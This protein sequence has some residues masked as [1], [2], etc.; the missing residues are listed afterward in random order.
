MWFKYFSKANWDMRLWRYYN[1]KYDANEF[2]FT[3]NMYFAYLHSL[4]L[5]IARTDATV[6]SFNLILLLGVLKINAYLSRKS[7]EQVATEEQAAQEAEE[8]EKAK[9]RAEYRERLFINRYNVPTKPTRSLDDFL[10][11]ATNIAAIEDAIDF[12]SYDENAK[13]L[14]DLEKG[15]D[16]WLSD[17]DRKIM[18]YAKTFKALGSH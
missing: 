5:K 9:D 18:L 2:G 11:F 4:I 12:M 6:R 16:T 15:L 7:P 13:T 3:R 14:Q 17:E 10:F 1:L 8:R